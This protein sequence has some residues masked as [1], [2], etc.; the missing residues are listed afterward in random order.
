[1]LRI[2]LPRQKWHDYIDLFRVLSVAA[3]D[4]YY[5]MFS[6]Y[7][8]YLFPFCYLFPVSCHIIIVPIT[9]LVFIAGISDIPG[10][11]SQP[12]KPKYSS[13]NTLTWI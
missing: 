6:N 5:W 4:Q 10:V 12:K 1:M 2:L 7:F 11:V 13:T 8:R 3:R 9:Q